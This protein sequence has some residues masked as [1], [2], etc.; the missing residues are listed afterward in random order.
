[1][2]MPLLCCI[3]H[4]S[5]CNPVTEQ[6]S[7]RLTA[8]CQRCIDTVKGLHGCVGTCTEPHGVP[9]CQPCACTQSLQECSEQVITVVYLTRTSC[10]K[11]G[12]NEA[13]CKDDLVPPQVRASLRAQLG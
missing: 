7:P 13:E 9:P 2:I 6:L 12:D 5:C 3:L 4:A 1:V 11:S 8:G 10:L